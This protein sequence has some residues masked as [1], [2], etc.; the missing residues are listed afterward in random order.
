MVN[1]LLRVDGALGKHIRFGKKLLVIVKNFKRAKQE[2]GVIVGEY[3]C[4][5]TGID[6]PILLR[7]VIILTVQPCLQGLD[8]SVACVIELSVNQ[9]SYDVPQGDH[10]LDAVFSRRCCFYERHHAVLTVIDLAVHKGK[11]EASEPETE[12]VPEY[13]IHLGTEVYIGQTE[14]SVISLDGDTVELFDGTLIPLEM[15]KATFYKRVAENPFND[16]LKKAVEVAPEKTETEAKIIAMTRIGDFYEFFGEDAKTASEV[17]D[18][19]LTSRMMADGKRVPMCG[20]PFHVQ[21]KY[22]KQ[23]TDAGYKVEIHE[24]LNPERP[25]VV[26]ATYNELEEAKRLISDFCKAEYGAEADFSDLEKIGVAYTETPDEGYPIQVNVNLKDYSV[27]R[28]L[29]GKRFDREQYASL[30]ELTEKV[31][32]FL[33]FGELT[34]VSD[35]IL[36]KYNA[37]TESQTSGEPVFR[38]DDHIFIDT[39]RKEVSWIYYNPDADAGGQFVWSRLS[40]TVFKEAYDDFVQNGGDFEDKAQRDAFIDSIS[41]MAD[42]ELADERTPYIAEARAAFEAEPDLI[43]FT[44]EHIRKIADDIE[45]YYAELE[46]VKAG[47]AYEAEFGADGTRAFPGNA[48][49]QSVFDRELDILDS[50]LYRLKIDDMELDYKDGTL[51]ATDPENTWTGKEF[52]EFLVNEAFVFTDEGGVLGISDHLLADFKELSESYGVPLGDNRTIQMPDLVE[53]PKEK[54][55]RPT[56]DAFPGVPMEWRLNYEIDDDNLGVGTPEDRYYANVQAIR[57]LKKLEAEN[58]HAQDYEQRALAKY[59]GW[60]GLASCFEEGNKHYEELKN[61][62]TE[63]EYNAAR[64][65]T[66]TAFFTP[67]TVIRAIYQ[68]LDN[69]GFKRGNILEPSCGIGNFIGMKPK[70]MED[71][72]FYGVE[73]DSISGRIARQLYQK[74]SITVDGFEKTQFPDSF[75]DVAIGNVP[76]GQF[77]VPDKKY[78]KQGFLIHDYFFAKA[79]DKVRPGGIVAFITSRGTLDKESPAVRKYI[80]ER[81]DFLGAIRLPND[82]FKYAAGTEVTSDIIF[83]QKSPSDAPSDIS[84]ASHGFCFCQVKPLSALLFFSEFPVLNII[85]LIDE[86]VQRLAGV[87]R[88]IAVDSYPPTIVDILLQNLTR[89]P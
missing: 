69:M 66:L 76:F 87:L 12:P 82:T 71:A 26:E 56:F 86:V 30:K 1:R 21:D 7:E 81:A 34:D 42:C 11:G 8:F 73:L 59:V 83:L 57:L 9:F 15:D 35:E 24:V 4:I 48:P 74:A 10:S 60:G 58:R 6:Q 20:I 61:L 78:D 75:F 37:E 33:D 52:Y 77:K 27:E 38:T 79:L 2:I 23:L 50:I 28:Y 65:S 84:D 47:D 43:E 62:L 70:T 5:G 16:H 54:P 88:V 13:D 53:A 55:V 64:E 3:R 67:P 46:A 17:L 40:F 19:M 32:R 18:L 36:E 29:D 85:A 49:G 80:A 72:K 51:V 25:K 41:E 63:E 44:P 22:V 45:N 14:C 31:L 68:A 39:D 89:H